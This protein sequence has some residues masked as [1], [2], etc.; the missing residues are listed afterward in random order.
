MNFCDNCQTMGH[1]SFQCFKLPRS[2]IK[3]PRRIS[4]CQEEEKDFKE[5][6]KPSRECSK[7]SRIVISRQG[8][9]GKS[10]LNCLA[11]GHLV[12]DCTRAR[13]GLG[14]SQVLLI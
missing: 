13:T 4:S 12:Q 3:P 10:C 11:S 1:W 2:Q 7:P 6:S 8:I 14:D 5:C 9:G